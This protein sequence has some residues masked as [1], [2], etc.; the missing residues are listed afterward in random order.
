VRWTFEWSAAEAAPPRAAVRHLQ[1]LPEAGPISPRLE[2]LVEAAMREYA[3]CAEPR[4]LVAEIEPTEFARV[5]AGEGRNAPDTPLAHIYPQAERLALFAGTVGA[6]VSA[7]V[8][9]LFASGDPARAAM[10][11]AVASA[12]ADRVAELAGERYLAE[13]GLPNAGDR[14][15]LPYSPGYCGWDVTGQRAL[16]AWL[17][18]EAIGLALNASCL[19]DP[20]KSV[21]GVLVVGPARIHVFRP[22]FPFCATCPDRP[23]GERLA[24]L[25]GAA[26]RRAPRQGSRPPR[27]PGGRRAVA[28]GA[29][30]PASSGRR[31]P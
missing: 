20:L 18:P 1:G 10:L 11:D 8:R 7:R 22:R 25:V 30:P 12:A 21:S 29:S 15:V 13:T 3:A 26:R 5:Y 9:E 28:P 16:F 19:M 27:A 6:R 2:A 24:A 17:Q 23:C 31:R 4:A 14:R